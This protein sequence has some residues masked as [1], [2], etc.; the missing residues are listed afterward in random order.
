MVDCIFQSVTQAHSEKENPS[1]PNRSLPYDLPITT[2]CGSK[3]L[4]LSYRSL[5]G[6]FLCNLILHRC[7]QKL[8]KM[9]NGRI[10]F[11]A[12]GLAIQWGNCINLRGE[13]WVDYGGCAEG[14]QKSIS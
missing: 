1:S 4:P 9:G 11:S 6:A 7:S 12:G 13:E 8:N 2:D 10:S 5:V 14:Q 3:P